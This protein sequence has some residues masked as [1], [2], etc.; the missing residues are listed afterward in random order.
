[1]DSLKTLQKFVV[2]WMDELWWSMRDRVGALSMIE[3]LSNS[4]QA[5]GREFGELARNN[6][7]TSVETTAK[8]LSILGRNATVEDGTVKV[9][10]CPLWD[11]IRE[12]KLEYAFKCED[13]TC[14]PFLAGIKEGIGA[15]KTA[16]KTS[17]RLLHVEQARLEYKISKLES[18]GA[19]DS[20]VKA[21]LADLE[22]Q[23]EI[24]SKKPACIFHID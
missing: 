14:A 24:L 13:F 16:V 23:L 11:R 4:W 20:A 1:M 9:T 22:K 18:V 8:I 2:T 3:C 6:G 7:L 21:Q 17:M 12:G 19:S 10:K 15:K 5:A